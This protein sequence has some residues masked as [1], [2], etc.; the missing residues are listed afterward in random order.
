[1]TRKQE[2][3]TLLP[4]RFAR[5]APVMVLVFST[6]LMAWQGFTLKVDVSLIPLD[7]V[8]HDARG[9]TVRTLTRDDFVIYE[10]GEL[11]DIQYFEGV[12]APY[13]ILLL[14]DTSGSTRNQTGFMVDASNRVIQTLRFED[15]VAIATF[16]VGVTKLVDWR[17]RFGV[18]QQ[19]AIPPSSGGT[20]LYGA[21]VWAAGELNRVSGRKGVLTL[22]DGIDGTLNTPAEQ[23][24][25]QRA[26]TAVEQSRAPFYFVVVG[27]PAPEALIARGRDRMSELAD[28]SGGRVMHPSTLADVAALYERVAKELSS[29]YSLGY[30][31]TRPEKDG[32]YR[33]IEVRTKQAGLQVSQSRT[34]YYAWANDTRTP[35]QV[36]QVTQS[37][38]PSTRQLAVQGAQPP[39]PQP[40]Q[41][42]VPTVAPVSPTQS[43]PTP[44]PL[45]APPSPLPAPPPAPVAVN[46][47][48]SGAPILITPI[49][50]A[51]LPPP[52]RESWRFDWEDLPSAARYQIVVT[53]P[54]VAVPI[55]EA[56]SRSSQYISAA[57]RVRVPARNDRGWTWKVR[58]QTAGGWGPWSE[59]RV[60]DVFVNEP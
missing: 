58:A 23:A 41:L 46:F 17:S 6:S 25:F 53:A 1:M 38:Q 48:E 56:E 19:V 45:P 11:Q 12:D 16:T 29:S 40:A 14:F 3:M 32:K 8:V 10:D 42:P 37:Q 39:T 33:R 31:S 35:Q 28:R 21:L 2:Q 7:V 55:I 34:G 4:F 5:L 24:A 26:R 49:D 54:G 20:D 47:P 36:Q 57:G 13:K 52:G 15:Q 27:A 44:P 59:I 60:F 43:Q 22:T 18:E 9:N 30:P 51:L 50:R